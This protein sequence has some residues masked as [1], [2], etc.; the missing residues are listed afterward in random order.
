MAG[1][2]FS[3]PIPGPSRHLYGEHPKHWRREFS[4]GFALV[5]SLLHLLEIRHSLGAQAPLRRFS[6]GRQIRLQRRDDPPADEVDAGGGFFDPMRR[7]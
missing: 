1:L 3:N 2:C 5:P 4:S 6:T 7:A